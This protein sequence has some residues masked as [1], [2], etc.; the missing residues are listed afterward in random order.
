MSEVPVQA[1]WADALSKQNGH[2]VPLPTLKVQGALT[3]D[4]VHVHTSVCMAETSNVSAGVRGHT[5]SSQAYLFCSAF[6][7]GVFRVVSPYLPQNLSGLQARACHS[8]RTSCSPAASSSIEISGVMTDCNRA[9]ASRD[10][11]C[12]CIMQGWYSS[13][14]TISIKFQQRP[15]TASCKFPGLLKGN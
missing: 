15:Y 3:C 1:D 7:S 10:Q 13:A 6:E 11:R 8:Q 14:C 9:C 2:C 12:R 4:M 5:F